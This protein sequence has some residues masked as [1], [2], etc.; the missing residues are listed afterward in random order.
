MSTELQQKIIQL[1]REGYSVSAIAQMLGC[2]RRYVYYVA[3]RYGLTTN[4]R[5]D[6]MALK[7]SLELA[8]RAVLEARIQLSIGNVGAALQQLQTAMTFIEKA[9]RMLQFLG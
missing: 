4:P 8:Y 2:S 9:L 6:K 7:E 1:L 5:T 3:Q